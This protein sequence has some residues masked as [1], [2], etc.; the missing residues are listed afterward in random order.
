MSLEALVAT[1]R[2][3]PA[4]AGKREIGRVAEAL[5]ALAHAA[6]LPSGAPVRNGDDAAAIPDGDGYILL[7][8]EGMLPRFVAHDPWFAGYSAVMVNVS[9]ILAMGGRPYAVVDVLFTGDSV[10]AAQ[11]LAG[12]RAA[13]EA[14][15][16][17]VV[18]GHTSPLDRDA[19]FV[20]AAIVGRA[21][22]LITSFDAQPGDALIFAAD[23]RG[24]LRPGTSYYDAATRAP[25]ERLRRAAAVLPQLS[26]AGLVHAGKDVSMAGIAGT[27]TMLCEGSGV[28]AT[29]DLERLPRPSDVD[30]PRWLSAFPS[31]GFLLAA[32][33]EHAARVHA[34]FEAVGIASATVGGFDATREVVLARGDERARFWDL[35]HEPLTGFSPRGARA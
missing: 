20:A 12:M 2:A 23:L 5:P 13:A 28:G 31:F 22:K 1:L 6:C 25:S 17:P 9:D 4:I 16:V 8:A 30:E 18:G 7:A 24:A 29:L 26:E 33:P 32:R 27:L 11:V 34:A 21:H 3:S 10:H 35:A 15:G 14:H 19:T